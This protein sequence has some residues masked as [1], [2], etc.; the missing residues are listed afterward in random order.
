MIDFNFFCTDYHDT[1]NPIYAWRELRMCLQLDRPLPDWLKK[2][3]LQCAEN[4]EQIK[5]GKGYKTAVANA[6]GYT[7]GRM[8]TRKTFY[9]EYRIYQDLDDLRGEE[10]SLDAAIERY[11]RERGELTGFE[12]LKKLYFERQRIQKYSDKISR[13]ALEELNRDAI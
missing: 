8:L 1:K 6:I 11:Q 5:P 12:A 9:D 2:Y 10:G 13:D 7:D 4:L 3:L